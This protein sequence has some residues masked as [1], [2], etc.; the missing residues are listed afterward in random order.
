LSIIKKDSPAN[1]DKVGEGILKITHALSDKPEKYPP[2][3]FKK[4]NLG[5]YRVF[6]KYSYRVSYKIPVKRIKIL[7]IRH[8]KQEPKEY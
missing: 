7:R 5:N 8:V 4:D 6:E 1:A 3:K 2:E